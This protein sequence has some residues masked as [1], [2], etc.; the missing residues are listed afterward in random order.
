MDDKEPGGSSEQQPPSH[1][2]IH[3]LTIIRP[4]HAGAP[5]VRSTFPILL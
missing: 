1:N 4:S 2:F 5:S 3:T